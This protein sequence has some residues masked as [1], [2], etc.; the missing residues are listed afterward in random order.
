MTTATLADRALI[1]LDR[2]FSPVP[3]APAPAGSAL[4]PVLG[5]AGLPVVGHTMALFGEPLALMRHRYDTYGPVSWTHMMGRRFV[6]LLGPDASEVALRNRDR[7]FASGPGWEFWI[8]PFFHRGIMLL[9]FD[10]HLH[11]RRVMQQAFTQERLQ[12]YLARMNP[13]IARGL[14]RWRPRQRFPLLA[15]FKQLTLDLATEVFVGARLGGE[16]EAIHR[17]FVDTVRAG[18]AILRFDVPGGRWSRGLKGRR[19]LERFFRRQ[20]P[21]RRAGAGQDLFSVLCHARS[22]DGVTFTDDDVVNHM[23]F[24]L[25]AAH[26]TTTGTMTTMA[27]YLARHPAWQERLRQESVALGKAKLDVADLDR[28]TL[29]DQV[30]KEATRLVAPVPYLARKTV[31]DTDVLGHFVPRDT[32]VVLAPQFSHHMREHWPD[33]E[34]FDPDRFAPDRRDAGAHPYA[35]HP[36]G[37]GVHKCIGLHF[38][39]MQVK[40]ILHQLLLRYRWSVPADYRTRFD[41][42]TLPVPK[43][44]LPV[45]LERLVSEP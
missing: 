38:A 27:Y 41:F 1:A 13:A 18:M 2:R 33:P 7:A 22:E 5:N 21:A 20:L 29:L 16:A 10:E 8:G 19:V 43:D 37:G 23:I 34:R 14:D 11:H 24:L 40:A 32:M 6:Y 12:G 44:G 26:D 30:I 42:T 28:L 45:L 39:G 15:S 4:E 31:A 36:F 25:M 35:W 17:A 9:D 3:L